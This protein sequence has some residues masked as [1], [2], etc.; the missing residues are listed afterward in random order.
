MVPAAIVI[1]LVEHIPIVPAM[2]LPPS[3][4]D[5]GGVGGGGGGGGGDA[6]QIAQAVTSPTFHV[7]SVG[8]VALQ[9]AQAVVKGYS[10][11]V[12][13]RVSFD[14][15]SH[16]SFITTRAVQTA[17]VHIKGKE[18]IEISTFGQQTKNCGLRAVYEL[19]VFPLQGGNGIKIEAYE[20]LTIAEIGNQHIEIRKGEY[21]YLQGLWFF[22]CES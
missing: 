4:W 17:G 11:N 21:P 3:P 1:A 22:G 14:A 13:M 19:D 6:Q 20:V 18:W 5:W 16:R 12:R 8:R 15:G 10:K 9:T 2:P 7:G